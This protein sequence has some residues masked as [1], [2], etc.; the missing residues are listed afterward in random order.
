MYRI[1]IRLLKLS[2]FIISIILFGNSIH[3]IAPSNKNLVEIDSCKISGEHHFPFD[4]PDTFPEFPYETEEE[5]KTENNKSEHSFPR[6]FIKGPL[7]VFQSFRIVSPSAI[8][9]YNLS[10]ANQEV[11]KIYDLNQSWKFDP[12]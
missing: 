6:S 11:T 4:Q 1:W 10:I 7:Y 2:L 3:Q 12:A 5:N 8:K 9:I